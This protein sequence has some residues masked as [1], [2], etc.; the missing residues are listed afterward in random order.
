MIGY[1]DVVIYA[2][3]NYTFLN[4]SVWCV[5]KMIIVTLEEAWSAAQPMDTP[6]FANS[7]PLRK[8]NMISPVGHST[9]SSC[10]LMAYNHFN[11]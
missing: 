4:F 8:R 9:F 1:R 2:N 3:D 11:I 6:M 5:I 7:R 10:A